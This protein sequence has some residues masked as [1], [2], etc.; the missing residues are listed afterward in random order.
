MGAAN[1]TY[2]IPVNNAYFQFPD[3]GRDGF[4]SDPATG[5]ILTAARTDGSQLVSLYN[6]NINV[7]TGYK[8]TDRDVPNWVAWGNV[9]ND[10]VV[11][12]N[13]TIK[14][15]DD[16]PSNEIIMARYTMNVNGSQPTNLAS[17]RGYHYKNIPGI[18]PGPECKG[19]PDGFSHHQD[20]YLVGVFERDTFKDF[21]DV[22]QPGK[23]IFT[24]RQKLIN[25]MEDHFE[26]PVE[27]PADASP[28]RK[29]DYKYAPKTTE[30][31]V[32][33]I[34]RLYGEETGKSNEDFFCE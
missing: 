5:N 32:D 16:C 6:L 17:G 3:L 1:P 30:E 25:Y 28:W 4:C 10:V 11:A 19:E 31:Y 12:A 26:P 29:Q 13:S 14:P 21:D 9:Q 33:Q 34:L 7:V 23:Q 24:S 27:P 22:D 15:D 2:I 18:C 8:S 20:M